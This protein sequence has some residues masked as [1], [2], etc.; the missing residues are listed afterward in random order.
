MDLTP[1]RWADWQPVKQSFSPES[2]AKQKS[3][4]KLTQELFPG[5]A[6]T[7]QE[8]K[9]TQNVGVQ[10]VLHKYQAFVPEHRV[11]SVPLL[12]RGSEGNTRCQAGFITHSLY[13]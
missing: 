11:C 3:A 2:V 7:A 9:Q 8:Q 6:D 4:T 10:L 13:D 12:L 5:K 1:W